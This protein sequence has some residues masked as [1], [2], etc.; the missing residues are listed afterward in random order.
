M[1]LQLTNNALD[2]IMEFVGIGGAIMCRMTCRNMWHR[3][4]GV[5]P[6]R[7]RRRLTQFNIAAIYSMFNCAKHREMAMLAFVMSPRPYTKMMKSIDTKTQLMIAGFAFARPG[8]AML[9]RHAYDVSPRHIHNII[10]CL[11]RGA[12]YRE[13]GDQRRQIIDYLISERKIAKIKIES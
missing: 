4:I 9:L 1:F 3:A 10:K 11:M 13:V 6:E 8:I 7:L 5:G 2:R 12:M